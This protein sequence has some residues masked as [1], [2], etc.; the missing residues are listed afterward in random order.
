M[1]KNILFIQ[2]LYFNPTLPNFK[3]R[4]ELLSE[5]FEG[6]IFSFTNSPE[7]YK[8][9]SFGDFK[10][11]ALQNSSSKINKIFKQTL[12]IIGQGLKV[13]KQKQ[14]DYIHCYDPLL[15]GICGMIIKWFTGAK[16]IIEV[17]G[18]LKTDGFL[19]KQNFTNTI[20][21]FL[22]ICIVNVTLRNA[23]MVKFLNEEQKSE[24]EG[25]IQKKKTCTFPDF[26]ATHVFDPARSTDGKY[27]F[28]LGHPFHRKGVDILIKAFL[29]ISPQ[30]PDQKLKIVGHCHGREKERQHYREIAQGNPNV[31]IL[32]PVFFDQAI[33]LFQNCTFFV[34]PSRSEAMGRVLIEAMACG[35]ALVGSRVGGIP[36]LIKDGENGFLF[37]SENVD[38]LAEKMR[39]LLKDEDLRNKMGK[40]GH[41]ICDQKFSS[42]KYVEYFKEMIIKVE[43]DD[44]SNR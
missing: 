34:L 19:E 44:R 30:F 37:E 28:F 33:G 14:I 31:E 24:W 22:F 40:M 26:T 12:Q 25:I 4:F 43:N 29:K 5:F 1:K 9:L 17:N 7:E 11:I 32:E 3:D 2:P 39:L 36:D 16:L 20:K 8:N 18:H 6:H 42:Q 13:N 27:I 38:D 21:R 35:K 23:D 41:S 15:L 10:Y